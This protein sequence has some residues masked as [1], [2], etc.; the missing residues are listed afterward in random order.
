MNE[1]NISKKNL[2]LVEEMYAERD[3]TD[4][5]FWD[6]EEIAL[7]ARRLTYERD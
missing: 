3:W 5:R 4:G 2:K 1:E 6:D 7:E